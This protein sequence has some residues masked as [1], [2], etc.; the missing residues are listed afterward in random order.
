MDLAQNENPSVTLGPYASCIWLLGKEYDRSEAETIAETTYRI[1]SFR[2][3]GESIQWQTPQFKTSRK[4]KAQ[5]G[6]W[7]TPHDS[8]WLL[9]AFKE[10]HPSME[11]HP[12]GL[13][14]YRT[15]W[16]RA[17]KGAVIS[18]GEVDFGD[19]APRYLE[20]ELAVSA[21][22]AG[23][24]VKLY[25]ITGDNQPDSVLAEVATTN[26]GGWLKW[27]KYRVPMKSVTG[28]RQIVIRVDGKNCNIRSWRIVN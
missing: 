17:S 8:S 2:D 24:E 23:G 15:N 26:T 1:A 22:N 12:R 10:H 11:Y 28:K 13:P 20:I 14:E 6:Q 7:I 9:F 25:D 18:Y 3:A 16:I 4:L 19:K 21:E 27:K 5:P